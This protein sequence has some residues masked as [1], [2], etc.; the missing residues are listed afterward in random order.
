MRIDRIIAQR[1]EY[2][3][4]I[5]M[6]MVRRGRVEVEGVSC[7][8]PKSHFPENAHVCIDGYELPQRVRVYVYH[9]PPGVLSTSFDSMGRP[10]VGDLLPIHHHLVGRLDME[11]RGLL[12]LSMDGHLTQALL[13]P[14]REVEREYCAWVEGDPDIDLIETL[15]NG[16]ETSLGLAKAKV[17]SIEGN[18][19]RLVVTEG[20]NRIVRR[21]LHNAGHSVLDLMRVR[22]GPI[23][24]GDIEEGMMRPITAT[25]ED[26]LNAF[27]HGLRAVKQPISKKEK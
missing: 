10:C 1:G 21:M 2:S 20:R 4:K 7:T 19:V 22:F 9:K 12:L 24:L 6:K 18:C 27:I 13:H 14:K 3:R 16:V 11:T 15:R 8:D 17:L 23:E 25:Q 26:I 5:A